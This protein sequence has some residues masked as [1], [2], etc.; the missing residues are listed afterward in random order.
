M[1][2]VK[3]LLDQGIAYHCLMSDIFYVVELSEKED[4]T[5]SANLPIRGMLIAA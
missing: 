1:R 2:E 3:V 5:F 4:V